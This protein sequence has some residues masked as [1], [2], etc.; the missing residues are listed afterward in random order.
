M[1]QPSELKA[2]VA[3]VLFVYGETNEWVRF[4][5]QCN[6]AETVTVEVSTNGSTWAVSDELYRDWAVLRRGP[7]RR[8]AC[9]RPYKLDSRPS[10]A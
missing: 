4:T 9:F 10:R 6:P 7:L 8:R 1:G 3:T 5:P 2:D